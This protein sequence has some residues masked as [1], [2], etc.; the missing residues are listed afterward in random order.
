MKVNCEYSV[1]RCG[2]RSTIARKAASGGVVAML[3]FF[4]GSGW[5][6]A[7]GVTA[8]RGEAASFSVTEEVQLEGGAIVAPAD[9]SVGQALIRDDVSPELQA[10]TRD[11]IAGRAD[12][13]HLLGT[14]FAL[15]REV[16]QNYESAAYWY[17]RAADRGFII[18]SYD[19]GVLLELGLGV[20]RDPARAAA[21]FREAA[22][23][24]HAEAQ[25]ALGLAYSRGSGV[26]RDPRE[27][28]NWFR[29]A[30]ASGNPR[31]A[32]NIGRL[33][34]DGDLGALD[35]RAAADWYRVAADAGYAEAKA[36]LERLQ[37]T[38]HARPPGT[39]FAGFIILSPD[40]AVV[41]PTQS[42][43]SA[44]RPEPLLDSPETRIATPETGVPVVAP[45]PPAATAEPT[46]TAAQIKEIQ[47]LLGQLNFDVGR[48]N[49]WM[50][51]KTSTA[52][53]AFQE[54]RGLP[55]TG[56]PSAEL[57]EALRTAVQS[58]LW[59]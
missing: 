24:G 49:G 12:A 26:V 52:I 8:R 34:E 25:N 29:R 33:Y 50:R 2:H 54:S 57:L 58:T 36:A 53:A 37:V 45:Q 17:R 10:I 15:G 43:A 28:L 3:L 1:A 48:A 9:N 51:R 42:T 32:Y 14:F 38:A 30:N 11:A 5:C 7:E 35:R 44:T 20:P 6:A 21:H 4:T 39:P 47:Q 41:V 27:A 23:A 59:N 56:R 18:A 22:D 19:L 40:T 46:T 16:P 31:G 55:V 13:E